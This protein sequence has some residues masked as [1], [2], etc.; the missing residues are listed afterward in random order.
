MSISV[1]PLLVAMCLRDLEGPRPGTMDSV[2]S[3]QIISV[4]PRAPTCRGDSDLPLDISTSISMR[5]CVVALWPRAILTDLEP[6]TM[7]SVHFGGRDSSSWRSDA[8]AVLQFLEAFDR[9]IIRRVA[10]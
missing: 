7:D 4:A 5:L 10:S 9:L 8:K 3:G 2:R 1:R 6:G